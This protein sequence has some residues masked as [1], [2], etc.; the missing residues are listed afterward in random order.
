MLLSSA[1]Y[2]NFAYTVSI[3]ARPGGRALR[4]RLKAAMTAVLLTSMVKLMN[5]TPG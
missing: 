4:R 2:A 1:V 5:S 3:L